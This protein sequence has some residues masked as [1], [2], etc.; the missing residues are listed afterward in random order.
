MSSP[1]FG[2]VAVNGVSFAA[3]GWLLDVQLGL[4]RQPIVVSGLSG[5]YEQSS[6]SS[7]RNPTSTLWHVFWAATGSGLIASFLTSP[8]ELVKVRMQS[9]PNRLISS[10][11]CFR[12]IL[13]VEGTRGCFRGL[14]CT[15]LRDAPSSGVYFV[16]YEGIR[17]QLL[18]D[19]TTHSNR[20]WKISA[21]ELAVLMFA[22]G[23]AGSVSWLSTYPADVLKTRIQASDG[24]PL[25]TLACLRSTLAGDGGGWRLLW[26]GV[27]AAVIPAFPTNAFFFVV[28]GWSMRALLY[29]TATGC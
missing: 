6:P 2:V 27:G 22:G 16:V 19:P 13:R 24:T 9:S 12:Q 10:W 1:L 7:S 29:Y 20:C 15:I 8:I 18:V 23:M 25:S 4:T 28:Y 21:R 14:T 11:Q 5:G 26:R 3:Y 17:R